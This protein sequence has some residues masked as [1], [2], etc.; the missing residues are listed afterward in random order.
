M[1][2]S[3]LIVPI[4]TGLVADHM[5]KMITINIVHKLIP[6]AAKLISHE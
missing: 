1:S 6:H 4:Y 3:I 5:K 2:I